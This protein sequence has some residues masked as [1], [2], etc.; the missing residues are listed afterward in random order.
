L[1]DGSR[2]ISVGA[3]LSIG[4]VDENPVGMYAGSFEL[5]FSYN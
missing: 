3:T 4:P 1:P 2:I 5:T